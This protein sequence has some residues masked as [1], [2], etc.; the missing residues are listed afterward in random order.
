MKTTI[1]A[2][3]LKQLFINAVLPLVL[4]QEEN[5][6]LMAAFPQEPEPKWRPKENERYYYI[7]ARG[8][9]IV[10]FWVDVDEACDLKYEFGNVFPT[11]EAAETH[12]ANY[13]AW[14]KGQSDK[15]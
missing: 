2:E 5:A 10:S 8:E 14:L 6:L 4:N 12:K 3:A 1:N 11:K 13:L 9:I 7:D 15:L